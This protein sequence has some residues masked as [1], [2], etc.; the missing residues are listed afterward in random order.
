[1]AG[2]EISLLAKELIQLTVKSSLVVLKSNLSLL[3]SVWLRKSYKPDSFHAQL[4]SIWKTRRKFEIQVVVQNLFQISFEEENNLEM[5]MEDRPWLFRR[6]LIIFDKLKETT[7]RSNIKLIFSPFWL[8]I[9]LAH[10]NLKVQLDA[11]KPLQRGIFITTDDQGKVWLPFK[12]KALSNFRFGCGCMGHVAKDCKEISN[13]EVE[14]KE[15]DLPY[16]L[17]LKAESNLMENVTCKRK[18]FSAEEDYTEICSV[19]EN[20]HKKARFDDDRDKLPLPE[21]IERLDGCV[22]LIRIGNCQ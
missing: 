10:Q 18:D 21:E 11:R 12:Y 22:F 17:A 2:D 15:D 16:S 8:K 4:R 19:I 14:K 1:M 20:N 6:Q 9:G 13:L 3:C 5:I 7:E